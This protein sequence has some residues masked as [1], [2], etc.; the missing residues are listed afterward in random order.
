MRE[1]RLVGYWRDIGTLDAYVR[2]HREIL[3]GTGYEVLIF[4][5]IK[6]GQAPE[7][8]LGLRVRVSVQNVVG[9]QQWPGRFVGI[10]QNAFTRC[11]LAG[12]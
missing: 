8:A 7:Q 6:T 2:A 3:E 1:H 4:H 10:Q 5:A 9:I 12:R 11:F